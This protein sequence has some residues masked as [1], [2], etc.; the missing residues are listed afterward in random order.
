[1]KAGT[2]WRYVILENPEISIVSVCLPNF[3]H[4]EVTAAAINAG[5]HVICESRC[6]K[7]CRCVGLVPGREEREDMHRDGLQ[8]PPL[9][10]VAEIRDLIESGAIGTPVHMLVR[11]RAGTQLD[12]EPSA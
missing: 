10:P 1:M 8:L 5:K 9:P 4:A 11:Y 12:P 6:R 3:L 2:D 7:V